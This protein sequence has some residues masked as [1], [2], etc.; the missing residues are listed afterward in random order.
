M[1]YNKYES[2]GRLLSQN[3]IP[4]TMCRWAKYV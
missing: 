2:M 4:D 3:F 1:T